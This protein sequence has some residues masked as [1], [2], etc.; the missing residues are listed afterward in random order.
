MP[1]TLSPQMFEAALR[2][3]TLFL[4][5]LMA[6]LLLRDFGRARAARIGAV[7]AVGV[8]AYAVCA[9]P[10]IAP[11]RTWWHAPLLALASGNAVVFWL[12]ARALFDD[13][14]VARPWHVGL[15]SCFAGVALV[16][17]YLRPGDALG[18]ALALGRIAF[19]GLA[20]ARTLATWRA[21]LVEGR[22]RLRGFI[23]CAI[24]IHIAVTAAS[25]LVMPS[26]AQSALGGLANAAALATMVVVIAWPLLRVAGDEL[27]V[28]TAT[29]A[30][31]SAV[32]AESPT[33]P[34]DAGLVAALGRLMTVERIQRREGLTIG[35]LANRLNLP[36][37]RVRR[38]INQGL[39][40]RNFNAFLNHHRV[41]EAKQAL[42]DPT[43][44][45]VPVLTIA[46]DAGF[47]S[48]GPFN[49]AF[50][51]E[52]GVT[53]TEYRRARRADPSAKPSRAAP[54]LEFDRT[55]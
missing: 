32:A 11:L 6:A 8:A 19:A 23:V 4:L 48:L 20:V 9:A 26:I 24:A 17:F 5:L 34:P 36:E 21:D 55:A 18:V 2:G 51:A 13:A 35:A 38:L 29:E 22:R 10:G 47:Q 39:G 53:P 50:K 45:E 44:A 40:Y 3:G 28:A 43:Q 31:A 15:W 54:D 7:F 42:G 52:T 25:D 30:A 37:Y 12:F 46:L 49:R 14:F 1:D 41:E 16:D 27:F 33:E